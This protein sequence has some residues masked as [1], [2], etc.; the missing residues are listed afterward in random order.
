MLMVRT[1][2]GWEALGVGCVLAWLAIGCQLDEDAQ[3]GGAPAMHASAPLDLSQLAARLGAPSKGALAVL[4][5]GYRLRAGRELDVEVDA[6][7]NA[8][9]VTAGSS[10][11]RIRRTGAEGGAVTPEGDALRQ[12]SSAG[13]SSLFFA[14]DDEVEEL[15]R[16]P[17]QGTQVG[18]DFELGESFSLRELPGDPATLEISE[19]G[20]PR[21]RVSFAK[22]WDA[23][24]QEWPVQLDLRG[25]QLRLALP[26][27]AHFPV[28]IDP[29][30]SGLDNRLTTARFRHTATLLL[31]GRLLLVGG[32]TAAGGRGIPPDASGATENQQLGKAPTATAELFDPVTG[33][34]A[35][36]GSLAH[37]RWGHTAT[38]LRD[39]RVLIAGGVGE[40][41]E[42]LASSELFNPAT[43]SFVEGSALNQAR[44]LHTATLLADDRVLILGGLNDITRLYW[45]NLKVSGGFSPY[46]FVKNAI[47]THAEAYSAGLQRFVDLG[48]AP[49]ASFP[50]AAVL[51]TD[52]RVACAWAQVPAKALGQGVIALQWFDPA[53]N[54][55]SSAGELDSGLPGSCGDLFLHLEPAPPPAPAGDVAMRVV[56]FNGERMLDGAK[57]V[58][59]DTPLPTIFVA[60]GSGMSA[61][62][63]FDAGSRQPLILG[64]LLNYSL[65]SSTTTLSYQPCVSPADC[66]FHWTQGDELKRARAWPT[67]TAMV[68]GRVLAVG[69]LGSSV[70]RSG[71]EQT[72]PEAVLAGDFASWDVAAEGHAATLL[73][74]GR[75][76][77]SGGGNSK[78][79]ARLALSAGCAL[80][81]PGTKVFGCA[82]AARKASCSR[83]A[84][85]TPT[86]RTKSCSTRRRAAKISA[87]ASALARAG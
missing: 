16:V 13:A 44:A 76:L 28:V 2:K 27:A 31:D 9:R 61:A 57:F 56:A 1:L 17:E 82:R 54:Q 69:G 84:R 12:L 32:A 7:G 33:K 34:F 49:Q 40:A 11:L 78:A 20:A 74:D 52:G 8:L 53:R 48:A 70:T 71:A 41:D 46:F 72:L 77:V 75:V 4:E 6:T 81:V 39:G 83:A 37:A 55:F 67:A 47:A 15:I 64:G 60:A 38:L 35:A 86:P 18:Y 23:A 80:G 85:P 19:G 79:S 63:T 21:L 14:L 43:N 50:H 26:D 36:A 65:T 59:H 3:A 5:N 30:W 45:S 22:A 24:G 87:F 10:A 42:A 73:G 51:S 29:T 66:D 68:S 62:M 25:S 58:A